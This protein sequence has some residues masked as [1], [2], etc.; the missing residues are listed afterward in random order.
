M[1]SAVV[2]HGIDSSTPYCQQWLWERVVGLH[3]AVR[4]AGSG[5]E[6]HSIIKIDPTP[7]D[8]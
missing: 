2:V 6:A 7:F 4:C 1:R 5:F 8:C 3:L